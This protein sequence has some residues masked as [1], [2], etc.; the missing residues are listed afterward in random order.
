MYILIVANFTRDFSESD[1]GRF[2]YVA[3]MLAERNIN[4][5][6]VTSGF[7]HGAKALRKQVIAKWPF[8]ITFLPEKGYRRNVCLKRFYSHYVWGKNVKD[9]LKTIEKPDVVYCA[10]P[11]LSGP[12]YVADYCDKNGIRFVIDIQDL[13]P[14]AFK[15]VFNVPMISSVVFF[16]FKHKAESIYKRADAV[17]AVS[18]TYVNRALLVNQKCKS[19]TVVFLGTDLDAFDSYSTEEPIMRK[20]DGEVWLVYCGTLGSSYDLV[21]VFNAM[22]ILSK[23]GIRPKFI[24]MGNGPQREELEQYAA[25]KDIDVKFTGRLPYNK[26]CALLC[27]CD[28]ALNPIMHNAAQSIINKHGDYAASGIPVIS[29][30]ENEEYRT[31]VDDYKMGFNCVN[32]DSADIAEKIELL[33]QDKEL[34]TKMGANAR[35]CAEEKFDRKNSYNAL[36]S[37]ILGVDCP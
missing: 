20:P 14:E 9:Y 12:N 19:G 28:I 25:S 30:Q 15:M 36:V 24:I 23:N 34:R 11:S 4:V 17:C 18:Q 5:E 27:E 16:P 26:M 13:W 2:S 32:G 33:I 7:S 37:V 35:K 21:C 1:N 8:K 29:T 10:V 6:I 31:L 22:E 3:R